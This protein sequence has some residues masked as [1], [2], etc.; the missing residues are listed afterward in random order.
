MPLTRE[1][2]R[3]HR[4]STEGEF[5]CRPRTR[6]S[7]PAAFS[8]DK[9]AAWTHTGREPER[10]L[11]REEMLDDITLYWLTNTGASSSRSYWDGAQLGGGPF[12][13][14]EISIPVGVTIFPG[15]IHRAPRSWAEQ[16]F[17][18]VVYWNDVDRGGHF[19]AWEEPEL[20]ADEVRA[21]FRS[22]R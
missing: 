11:T 13:A 17:H 2:A 15:E 22:L 9:F 6:P 20:F 18:K 4:S 7:A 5:P 1:R 3:P 21:A 8:Y 12:N 19:A 10:A 16:A 14:V